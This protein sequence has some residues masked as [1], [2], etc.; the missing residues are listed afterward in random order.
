MTPN[1]PVAPAGSPATANVTAPVKFVRVTVIDVTPLPFCAIETALRL[2]ATV[3]DPGPTTVNGT[4]S[5]ARE[6]P[7]P[8]AR[9]SAV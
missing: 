3:S 5:V 9:N 4:E 8:E 7:V 1:V 6:M 2:A